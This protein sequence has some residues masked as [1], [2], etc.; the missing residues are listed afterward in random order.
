MQCSHRFFTGFG[1]LP[2]SPDI[3][4]IT[5]A[6]AEAL[7]ALPFLVNSFQIILDFRNGD[8]QYDILHQ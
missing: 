3:P 5:E 7:D 6:Q 8:G 2:S 4:Q 1:A